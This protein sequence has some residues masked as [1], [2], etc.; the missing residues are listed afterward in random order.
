MKEGMT[1][2][3]NAPIINNGTLNGDIIN[4]TYHIGTMKAEDKRQMA[5]DCMEADIKAK[6]AQG[7]PNRQIVAP[8]VAAVKAGLVPNDLNHD[9]FNKKYG[10]DIKQPRWSELKLKPIENCIL[11]EEETEAYEK[12]YR[13]LMEL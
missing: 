6:I 10:S 7:A 1:I 2:N 9:D 5:I 13:Q 4:P 8:Y 3:Y 12:R 11:L